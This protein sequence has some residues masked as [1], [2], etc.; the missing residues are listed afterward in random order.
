MEGGKNLRNQKTWRLE[1]CVE[2]EIVFSKSISVTPHLLERWEYLLKLS[3]FIGAL[4][5]RTTLQTEKNGENLIKVKSNNLPRV[6]S[7]QE[8]FLVEI[9]FHIM[10]QLFLSILKILLVSSNSP[11]KQTTTT[12]NLLQ[13]IRP[14]I[15]WEISRTPKSPF[16]IIWPLLR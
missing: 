8:E 15:F 10:S 12:K 16:E 14:F 6:R 3:T 13:R 1:M 4:K 7:P 11:K 2:G 5:N 9:D